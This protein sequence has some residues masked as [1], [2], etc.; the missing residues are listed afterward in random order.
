VE[1]YAARRYSLRHQILSTK[2]PK[3]CIIASASH[4]QLG[5]DKWKS[6]LDPDTDFPGQLLLVYKKMNIC[7]NFLT[8]ESDRSAAANTNM[9]ILLLGDSCSGKVRKSI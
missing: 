5:D 3:Y 1:R 8:L 2:A 7:G 6:L 9:K 4:W